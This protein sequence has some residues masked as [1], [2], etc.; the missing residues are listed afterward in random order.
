LAKP[1]LLRTPNR[2][3][4]Y[5]AHG[6]RLRLSDG[7]LLAPTFAPVNEAAAAA[8]ARVRTWTIDRVVGN[9]QSVTVWV[10][11]VTRDGVGSKVTGA[12]TT[13]TP[14]ALPVVP[15]LV[16]TAGAIDDTATWPTVP[17]DVTWRIERSRDGGATWQPV[18]PWL[19]AGTTSYAVPAVPG[20]RD[21]RLRARRGIRE[22]TGD[23]VAPV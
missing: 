3:D 16:V 23:P 20:G 2:P 21:Y 1:Q 6:L 22:A 18:S 7:T 10:A 15:A 12:A 17:A 4:L 13:V 5:P 8:E 9:D 14:V 11:A 19:P